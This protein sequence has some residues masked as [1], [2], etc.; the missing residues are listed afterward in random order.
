MNKKHCYKRL[1][2]FYKKMTQECNLSRSVL[3]DVLIFLNEKEQQEY[4]KSDLEEQVVLDLVSKGVSDSNK[5]SLKV[6]EKARFIVFSI[7]SKKRGK[8]DFL[9]KQI[10]KIQDRILDCLHKNDEKDIRVNDIR[11]SLNLYCAFCIEAMDYDVEETFNKTLIDQLIM[12][13]K[14]NGLKLICMD[15]LGFIFSV[16]GGSFSISRRDENRLYACCAS[17]LRESKYNCPS[18]LFLL[19][20]LPIRINRYENVNLY[21]SNVQN[22]V[23]C[24]YERSAGFEKYLWY[25]AMQHSDPLKHWEK[26]DQL[27]TL[28]KE[29]QKSEYK[30]EYE[31]GVYRVSFFMDPII[32][33]HSIFHL[34][35][36]CYA[37]II[38]H[39]VLSDV[40]LN[41]YSIKSFACHTEK[42]EVFESE[43]DP[44][45][46]KLDSRN[47]RI[48]VS[49]DYEG[50]SYDEIRHFAKQRIKRAYLTVE[51][52]DGKCEAIDLAEAR[53]ELL[54]PKL[55][56][57]A[58][59]LQ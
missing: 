47:E 20:N 51:N 26:D 28:M 17:K 1:K 25:R 41:R 59:T 18:A 44:D 3:K 10:T 15:Y 29:I 36:N 40:H 35:F 19:A 21:Y 7:V 48:T 37:K 5:Y 32:Y 22:K 33:L 58:S 56:T 55:L 52:K 46:V 23:K 31:Y 8:Y 27:E 4:R 42:G 12:R 38:C 30:D 2:S 13:S 14:T 6:Y 49:I 16:Q 34:E 53:L 57:E 50:E 43:I 45:D 11:F 39:A 54:M 9:H 24:A